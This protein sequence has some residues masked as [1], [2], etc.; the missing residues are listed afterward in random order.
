VAKAVGRGYTSSPVTG[1]WIFPRTDRLPEFLGHGDRYRLIRFIGED[2]LGQIWHGEDISPRIAV[3]IRIVRQALT[4]NPALVDAFHDR[5]AALYPR[6]AHPNIARAYPRNVGQDGPVEFVVMEEMQGQTLT[7][8]LKRGPPVLRQKAFTIGAVIA[9]ALQAAHDQGLAHEALTANS[10]MLVDDGSVKVMDFGLAAL[11]PDSHQ[12]PGAEGSPGDVRALASLLREMLGS[13]PANDD[14]SEGEDAELILLWNSS[15][16][17]NPAARPTARA[18]A[19]AFRAA[20]GLAAYPP[21]EAPEDSVGSV[22][23]P[24]IAEPTGPADQASA[25][26]SVAGVPTPEPGAEASPENG[27]VDLGPGR[28]DSDRA[29]KPGESENVPAIIAGHPS[30]G[31]G[32]LLAGGV[33]L[34]TAVLAFFLVR[35][36]F[37]PATRQPARTSPGPTTSE[38]IVMPDLRGM[39]F[40]EARSLL[41][42]ANLVLAR[43]VE[44]HGEPGLVVATD[45]GLGRLV[46]PGTPVTLYLGAE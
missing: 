26:A 42:E 40:T 31:T 46:R 2:W 29:D 35:P 27:P 22:D 1:K 18:L 9:E 37:D 28:P 32:W 4:T 41:E 39:T 17:P 24:V 36:G 23:T 10:V 45:P 14:P 19:S 5:L 30:G 11:R 20:A 25:D 8:R 16:D 44:A 13:G 43:D 6:L 21:D 38:L 3:T 12:W 33:V 15:L 7:H 34:L